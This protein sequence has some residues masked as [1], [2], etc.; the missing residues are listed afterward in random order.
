MSL[1]GAGRRCGPDRFAD[2]P[3]AAALPPC[4]A[5]SARRWPYPLAGDIACSPVGMPPGVE[6]LNIGD[7]AE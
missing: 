4:A 3:E 2:E 6:G 5:N 1:A 7:T